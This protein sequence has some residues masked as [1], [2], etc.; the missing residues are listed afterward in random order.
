MAIPPMTQD[1]WS[2]VRD[3]LKTSTQNVILKG[4][5]RVY[6]RGDLRADGQEAEAVAEDVESKPWGRLVVVPVLPSDGIP[7]EPLLPS[8]LRFLL[9]SE[10]N[11][12]QAVGYPLARDLELSQRDAARRLYTFDPA[13]LSSTQIVLASGFNMDRQWQAQPLRDTETTT[14]TVYV[15]SSWWVA[16]ASAAD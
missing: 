3:W 7:F 13:T 12:L 16:A 14:G 2:A 10:F 4:P 5:N 9:V 1:L 8:Q 11:D 15:S 6:V